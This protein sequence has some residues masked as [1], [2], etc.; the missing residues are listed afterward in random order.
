LRLLPTTGVVYCRRRAS[1][2]A[3]DGGS[4]YAFDVPR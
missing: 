3:A 4:P 2:T 1:S